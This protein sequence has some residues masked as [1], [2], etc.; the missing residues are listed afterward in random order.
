MSSCSEAQ[1]HPAF[2][3]APPSQGPQRPPPLSHPARYPRPTARPTHRQHSF[4]KVPG[5]QL[6]AILLCTSSHPRFPRPAGSVHEVEGPADGEVNSGCVGGCLQSP[7]LEMTLQQLA[8]THRLYQPLGPSL[9]PQPPGPRRRQ[10]GGTSK[11]LGQG[12]LLSGFS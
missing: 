6:P 11:D 2:P 12:T 1:V 3:P 7:S 8:Q 5:T 9:S 4:F 10:Q